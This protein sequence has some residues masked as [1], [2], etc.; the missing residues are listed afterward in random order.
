M[1]RLTDRQLHLLALV[2]WWFF[3]LAI[4][5]R[6]VLIVLDPPPFTP[7]AMAEG[8]GFTLVLIAFPLTGALILRRQP[9]NIVGWL[10]AAIGVI[11]GIAV[12]GDAYAHY[13]L[14]LAPGTLPLAEVGAAVAGGIWAPAL[15]LMGTFLVL[16]FPDGRLPS[17]RW[18]PLA[19]MSGTVIVV[20]TAAIYL[21]TGEIE[22]GPGAGLDNPLAVAPLATA[23]DRAFDVLIPLFALCIAGC[24][25]G[26]VVRFRRSHGT[27]RLQLKWL[28]TAAA[29]VG[30]AFVAGIFSPLTMPDD[31][32]QPMWLNALDQL[33][34]FLF[35]LI[36]VAI[37]VAVLRHRLYDIDLVINRA[38]VYGALTACLGAAY[39]ISVLVLR[40]ALDPLTG[41]SDVAVAASTLGVAA[42]FRPLRTR[43]QSSVDRRFYRSKYDAAQALD[44]FTGRLRDEV[45]VDA[46]GADLLAAVHETVQPRDVSLWLP[47]P[48]RAL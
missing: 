27:E 25:A 5:V 2:A 45:D 41:S 14:V 33:S 47:E 1:S 16:L 20:L 24:A 9:R 38:L 48:R 10:L 19:W 4:V 26:L 43:I 28:A 8:A 29:L 6:G 18:R 37:G 42:L 36:P 13:G 35:A 30:I 21:S 3:A 12:G 40:L 32:P 34:F 17:R 44:A 46:V 15:G 22:A 31:Q 11:W 23:I 7:S 39:L